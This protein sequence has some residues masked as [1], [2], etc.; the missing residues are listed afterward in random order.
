M[1]DTSG[2]YFQTTYTVKG[3]TVVYSTRTL[4]TMHKLLCQTC[5]PARTVR[6]YP[7]AKYGFGL[8]AEMVK[9]D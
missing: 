1:K 2:A 5:K 7:N 8:Y 6:C 4:T 9:H 3:K